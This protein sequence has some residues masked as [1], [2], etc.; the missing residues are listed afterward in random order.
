M[1]RLKIAGRTT[2]EQPVIS[3]ISFYTNTEGVPLDIVLL[4]CIQHGFVVDWIDYIQ[5]CLSDGQ[6]LSTITSRIMSAVT[7]IY[8]KSYA[9]SFKTSLEK[10]IA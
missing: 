3:G 6:N 5:N 1:S 4:W 10:A 2:S 8:G 7:E 9:S